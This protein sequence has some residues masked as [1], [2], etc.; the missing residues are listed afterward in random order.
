M[1]SVLLIPVLFSALVDVFS[2][3]AGEGEFDLAIE[4]NRL[5]L[6]GQTYKSGGV[7]S[8]LLVMGM[9]TLLSRVG[10]GIVIV[11]LMIVCVA[12]AVSEPDSWFAAKEPPKKVKERESLKTPRF[13][14]ADLKDPNFPVRT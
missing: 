8:G 12:L 9:V 7:I 4:A 5:F 13:N 11:I 14:P 3:K 6:N 2:Y 10:T 1:I